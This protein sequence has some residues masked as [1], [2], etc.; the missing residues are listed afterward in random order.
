MIEYDAL[1]KTFKGLKKR[2]DPKFP[3]YIYDIL[4]RLAGV[5]LLMFVILLVISFLSFAL[6][7][8][9]ITIT[10][11]IELFWRDF[12]YLIMIPLSLPSLLGT[13]KEMMKTKECSFM[14]VS[15]IF[16]FILISINVVIVIFGTIP[17]LRLLGA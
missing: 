11:V 2:E 12:T 8:F 4:G 9:N 16:M 10:K 15:S 7:P 17:I 13:A 3:G 5:I 1:F 6:K 14:W